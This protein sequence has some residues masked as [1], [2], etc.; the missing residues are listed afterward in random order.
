MK[1]RGV[2]L[3]D[4]FSMPKFVGTGE[5]GDGAV[6]QATPTLVEAGNSRTNTRSTEVT[7]KQKA[8]N[9]VLLQPEA[10]VQCPTFQNLK[11][12][13]SL[14][15]PKVPLDTWPI[16]GLRVAWQQPTITIPTDWVASA[17]LRSQLL[18]N[19]AT[20][21]RSPRENSWRPIF[22]RDLEVGDENVVPKTAVARSQRR[23]ITTV[24]YEELIFVPD[25]K[26]WPLGTLI[27]VVLN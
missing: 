23:H 11:Q 21:C 5:T 15:V 24:E 12:P 10:H 14:H 18:R 13:D 6:A 7:V 27:D 16:P 2:E 26:T 4:P 17:V 25:W 1:T 9:L 3:S 20:K 8:I 22:G 19:L